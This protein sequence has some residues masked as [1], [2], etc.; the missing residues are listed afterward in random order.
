MLVAMLAML[1]MVNYDVDFDVGN[2][3][4]DLIYDILMFIG[5]VCI[6]IIGY[7]VLF[8][9]VSCL[10]WDPSLRLMIGRCQGRLV[11]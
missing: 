5:N 3:D 1:T 8:I 9:G 4:E 10:S 7:F 2:D 6:P 11:Q